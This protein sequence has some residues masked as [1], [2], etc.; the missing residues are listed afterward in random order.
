MFY[1]WG[2]LKIM[3]P[4]T[5]RY[6]CFHLV[7]WFQIYVNIQ[8]LYQDTEYILHIEVE[9]CQ[10]FFNPSSDRGS[11]LHDDIW[12]KY[13]TGFV[14]KLGLWLYSN[15]LALS[16]LKVSKCQYHPYN[17]IPVEEAPDILSCL[18]LLPNYFALCTLTTSHNTYYWLR[19]LWQLHTLPNWLIGDDLYL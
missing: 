17:V 12:R 19:T 3:K 4:R 14:L 15:G 7:V 1:F 13:A 9:Y 2:L 18:V 10:H 8:L 16:Q 5:C 11:V 6:L